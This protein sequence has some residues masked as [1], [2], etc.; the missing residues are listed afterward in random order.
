[1]VKCYGPSSFK[2]L[3]PLGYN[4]FRTKVINDIPS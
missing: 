4:E 2:A 3:S 1:M